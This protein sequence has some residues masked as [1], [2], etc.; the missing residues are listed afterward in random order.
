[1]HDY[2]HGHPNG[3]LGLIHLHSILES[4]MPSPHQIG[5]IGGE[6]FLILLT[7]ETKSRC[8]EMIESARS[9]LENT[10]FTTLDGKQLSITASFS[11]VYLDR[12][13]KDIEPIYF[14]LDE[15]LYQAKQNGKNCIVN[16][17]EDEIT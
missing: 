6:E 5:R 7:N 1:M 8:L 16:A 2:L 17:L 9:N 13:M 12:E 4:V 10:P 15:G 3:D 11:W 14:I